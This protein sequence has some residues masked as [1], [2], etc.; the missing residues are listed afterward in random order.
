MRAGA[1]A[2][3]RAGRVG[4]VAVLLALL[5]FSSPGACSGEAARWRRALQ[6]WGRALLQTGSFSRRGTEAQPVVWRLADNSTL[7]AFN[8]TGA[9]FARGSLGRG[10]LARVVSRGAR[11]CKDVALPLPAGAPRRAPLFQD[12]NSS[13]LTARWGSS[14]GGALAPL[15]TLHLASVRILLPPAGGGTLELAQLQL[16]DTTT[17][18]ASLGPLPFEEQ[19]VL[20]W[21]G[22]LAPTALAIMDGVNI[23]L[24]CQRLAE[25]QDTAC[26]TLNLQELSML[27]VRSPARE[28]TRAGNGWA[29]GAPLTI[30]GPAQQP[31]GSSG[32]PALAWHSWRTPA[33]GRLVLGL[34]PRGGGPAPPRRALPPPAVAPLVRTGRA[35]GQ[36]EAWQRGGAQGRRR[37]ARPRRGAQTSAVGRSA[38]SWQASGSRGA[39][40][41]R[42][43]QRR[44]L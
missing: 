43:A 32:L 30:R 23:S 34:D 41:N 13:L 14:R 39:P 44:E 28:A 3:G 2:G 10:A 22:T 21:L 38:A 12:I 17:V 25:L 40:P 35:S 18:N 24:P 4:P 31:H 15:A 26:R 27:Q 20:P 37:C 6:Q 1:G 19:L 8:V 9:R 7:P 16:V 29:A 36:T 33:T 42:G 5:L 11:G